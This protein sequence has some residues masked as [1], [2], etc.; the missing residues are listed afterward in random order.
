M[1]AKEMFN[2]L[3]LISDSW[4]GEYISFDK[5]RLEGYLQELETKLQNTPSNSDYGKLPTINSIVDELNGGKNLGW[6]PGDV[7]PIVNVIKSIG[8]FE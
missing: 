6:T 2:E 8:N 5:N 4:D 1:T 3:T 7:E